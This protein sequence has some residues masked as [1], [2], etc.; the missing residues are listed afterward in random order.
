MRFVRVGMAAVAVLVGF[1]G[2][3]SAQSARPRAEIGVWT[4]SI[5]FK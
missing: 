5:F 4:A 3:A 2:L 1:A